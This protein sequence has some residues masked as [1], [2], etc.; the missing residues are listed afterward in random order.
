MRANSDRSQ[1][2]AFDEIAPQYGAGRPDF[3]ADVVDALVEECGWSAGDRVIEIGPATG[4]LTIPMAA[5]GLH[6]TAVEPG[7]RLVEV[8]RA[9]TERLHGVEVVNAT[10]EAFRPSTQRFDGV[11]AANAFHWISPDVAYD[12]AAELLVD[13]GTLGLLW[14][15]PVAAD[16]SV[17]HL[18]NDQAW[19]EPLGDLRR[20]V[21][22]DQHHLNTALEQGRAEMAKSKRFTVPVCR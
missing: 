11:V 1:R 19:T 15:Y 22:S 21:A 13:D 2:L 6:I 7:S 14:N 16:D 5:R 3:D 12:H 10:F 4:Q 20:D 8:L 18:L 17:Q 9:R